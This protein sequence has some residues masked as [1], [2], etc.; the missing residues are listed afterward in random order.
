MHLCMRRS[1]PHASI[2]VSFSRPFQF[3]AA[4]QSSRFDEEAAETL[5]ADDLQVPEEAVV[6]VFAIL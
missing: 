1:S 3:K 6:H 5:V 4:T 2:P